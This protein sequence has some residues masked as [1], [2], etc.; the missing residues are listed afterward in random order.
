M[1]TTIATFT[2]I[3]TH[4][5]RPANLRRDTTIQVFASFDGSYF[6]ESPDLGMGHSFKENEPRRI[7]KELA[8]RHGYELIKQATRRT[9]FKE[10]LGSAQKVADLSKHVDL[11]CYDEDEEYPGWLYLSSFYI[12]DIQR[13]KGDNRPTFNVVLGSG[14]YLFDNLPD[15]ERFLWDEFVMLETNHNLRPCRFG[16]DD[17][18]SYD[19]YTD[20]ST[21]NGWDNVCV[22]ERVHNKILEEITLAMPP[23]DRAEVDRLMA[24]PQSE[25]RD[26]EIQGIHPLLMEEIDEFRLYDYGNCY[27]TVIDEDHYHTVNR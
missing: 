8:R 16:W 6:A 17:S 24:L 26:D 7:A 11:G 15:A 13:S 3:N 2:A 10:F 25:W 12:E 19:G 5:D 18:E 1:A 20:G 23:R 4:D 27:T 21:W 9:T 14:E 22:S